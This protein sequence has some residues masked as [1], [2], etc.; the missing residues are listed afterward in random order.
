MPCRNTPSTGEQESMKTILALTIMLIAADC[1]AGWLQQAEMC[2][3]WYKQWTDAAISDMKDVPF[4]IGVP[5]DKKI[6]E[7]AHKQGTKVLAYVTFYQMPPHEYQRANLA[8]HPDWNVIKPDGSIGISCFEG[9]ENTG[10][11]TVCPNSPAFRDY[12]IAYTKYMMDLGVDGLF[13]DNG[14]PDVECVAPKFKRHRHIYRDKDNIYAYRKLLEAVR[15]R[16]K[17]YG[18]DKVVIVNAGYPNQ[19]WVGACDGQMLESYICTWASKT[20]WHDEA[21]LLGWQRQ[22]GPQADKG[23][24]LI[25]LSY[26]GYTESPPRE[27]AFY[28]Y[29]WARLSGF[30][31]ADWF[32][33]KDAARDLYKLRLGKPLGPMTTGD[34]FHMREFEKGIVVSSESKGARIALPKGRWR[35]VFAGKDLASNAITLGKSVGRV[36]LRE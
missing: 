15:Y 3:G 29:S 30:V 25:A 1:S 17:R 9:T 20:R 36:Y 6:I 10:W 33:A 11:K 14:H 8:E 35:D 28:C 5:L 23:H 18:D 27:D 2:N 31:W 22:W 7:K 4:V 34:G 19:E 32:S 21:T 24:T 12:A 16:V 13:I 26:I